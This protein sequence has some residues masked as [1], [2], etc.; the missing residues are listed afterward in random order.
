MLDTCK[1]YAD[2]VNLSFNASKTKCMYFDNTGS[3]N[4]DSDIVFMHEPIEFVSKVQLLGINISTDYYDRYISDTVRHFYCST[5]EILFD[6]SS[7]SCDIKSRLM[8]TYCLDLYGSSL[9]NYSK[10]RVNMSV[11]WRKVVH[12]LWKL[13][14]MTQ[15]NL[16][17]TI[18]SRLPIEITLEKRWA[19][20]SHS[21][22]N[23]NNLIIKRTFISAITLIDLSLEITIDIF[24]IN[25][26]FQK[27]HVFYQ[28]VIY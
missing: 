19:K 6:F 8:S 25:I 13:P 2:D 21:C 15:C 23:S 3:T 14:N 1:Q 22:L 16:L 7:I 27:L 24:V 10:D 12:R 18:N 11:A 20:F 17:P 9:W 5:N 26:R 4:I 28:L